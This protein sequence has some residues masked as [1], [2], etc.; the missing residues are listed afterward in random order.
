MP[1]TQEED[2][3]E[4]VNIDDPKP[5][6]QKKRGIFARMLD[7]DDHTDANGRPPSSQEKT[8]VWNTL[9]GR[10]RGQSGQGSELGAIPKR[11]AT[12]KPEIIRPEVVQEVVKPETTKPEVAKPEAAKA[13]TVKP[14]VAKAE[15]VKPDNGTDA[16]KSEPRDT[17]PLQKQQ[18]GDVA[19]APK[20]ENTQAPEIKVDS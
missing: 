17:A 9:T 12:P 11:E 7:S 20:S 8:G 6:P 16:A 1:Q 15:V 19:K 18:N 14:A 13:E 4:D 3:F 2:K 5:L 10:K